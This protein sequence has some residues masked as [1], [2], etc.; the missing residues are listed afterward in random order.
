MTRLFAAGWP[1]GRAV[2]YRRGALN[3]TRSSSNGDCR[4]IHGHIGGHVMTI[5]IEIRDAPDAARHV[6]ASQ[7]QTSA[8]KRIRRVWPLFVVGV[9][10]LATLAW[11]ALL[12]WLLYRAVLVLA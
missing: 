2:T 10:V 1:G 3:V 12:G 4:K 5:G 6:P 8:T 9:G 11:M 7:Q